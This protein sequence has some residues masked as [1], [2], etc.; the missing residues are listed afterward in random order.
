[1]TRALVS[2]VM[3]VA[4]TLQV[5]TSARAAALVADLSKHL[6]AITTG[7]AGSDVLLYGAVDGPGDVVI[8]VR[9]PQEPIVMH[10]KSRII[11]VWANTATMTF[12][13]APSFYAVAA[14]R[15]L[16]E[17][18]STVTLD[19]QKI[20]LEHL[21]LDLGLRASPN[22]AEEWEQAL[23]RNMQRRGLYADKVQPVT[24]LGSQLFRTE[25][26][27]PANVPTGQYLVEV[28]LLREGRIVQAQTIPLIV[29]K[30]GLE[31]EIFDFAYNESALYGLI[32]ILVALVSGWLAHIAFRKA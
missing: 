14:S 15:A 17:V 9:G 16:G 3:F 32:A 10:R 19:Q 21:N 24:F 30:I 8:V 13:E 7:F 12:E 27:F 5:T 28:Y 11:G 22:L 25:V 2:L 6:V 4:A 29:S 20:G 31:A 26:S 23:I 18:A 1:M